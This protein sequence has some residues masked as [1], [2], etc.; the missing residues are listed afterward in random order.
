MEG[1]KGLV[2][3]RIMRSA[4][5]SFYIQHKHPF[6]YGKSMANYLEMILPQVAIISSGRGT[7]EA[8]AAAK[9][10]EKKKISAAVYDMPSFDKENSKKNY[11]QR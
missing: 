7:H 3:L 9:E 4:S 8:L 1:S 10:L 2:Y 6:S 11:S 5:G